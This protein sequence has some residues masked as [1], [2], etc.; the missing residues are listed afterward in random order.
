MHTVELDKIGSQGT[1][2]IF[3]IRQISIFTTFRTIRFMDVFNAN[4]KTG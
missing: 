4:S 2:G 1:E 3:L